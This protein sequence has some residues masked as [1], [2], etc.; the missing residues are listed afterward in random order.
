MKESFIFTHEVIHF[1]SPGLLVEIGFC[2]PF[3]HVQAIVRRPRYGDSVIHFMMRDFES[4]YTKALVFRAARDG[5]KS[6]FVPRITSGY[7]CRY[8]KKREGMEH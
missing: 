4:L 2:R 7:S 1:Q 8:E 3:L 5:L 6:S